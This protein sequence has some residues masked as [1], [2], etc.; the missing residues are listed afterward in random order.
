MPAFRESVYIYPDQNGEPAWRLDFPLWWDRRAFFEKYRS[1][2]I[3]TGNPY[4]V[5]YVLL[6]TAGEALAW[7]KQCR[8]QFAQD[9]HSQ[10]PHMVDAMGQWESQLKAAR[11]VIVET[12]EWESGLS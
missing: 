11:W 8:V 2:Q 4:Y 3:D 10:K 9:P 1:R 5:G 12:S 6:L 7:D